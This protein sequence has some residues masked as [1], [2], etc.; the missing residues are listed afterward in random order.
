MLAREKRLGG[1]FSR[2]RAGHQADDD[3]IKL[4]ADVRVPCRESNDP[5][6][7]VPRD[8]RDWTSLGVPSDGDPTPLEFELTQFQGQASPKEPEAAERR[9]ILLISRS[10]IPSDNVFPHENPSQDI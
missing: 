1:Y 9:T 2:A 10:P 7:R 4:V 6:L 3:Q 5:N 8:S